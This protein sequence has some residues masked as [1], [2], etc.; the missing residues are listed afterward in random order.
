MSALLLIAGGGIGGLSA[1]IALRRIWGPVE[2]LERTPEIG[3][4]GAGT[5]LSEPLLGRRK[6]Q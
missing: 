4:S 5:I 6:S 3:E 2:V 1:A